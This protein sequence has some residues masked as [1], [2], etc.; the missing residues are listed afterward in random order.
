MT[1]PIRSREAFHSLGLLTA[2]V[3]ETLKNGDIAVVA[4]DGRIYSMSGSVVDQLLY[5][6]TQSLIAHPK[7]EALFDCYL[8]KLKLAEQVA[9]RALLIVKSKSSLLKQDGRKYIL[10]KMGG[11]LGKLPY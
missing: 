7:F 10:R 3:P 11:K 8:G 5:R 4:K 6:F 9:V 1:N 2:P